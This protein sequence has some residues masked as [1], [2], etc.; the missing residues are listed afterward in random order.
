MTRGHSSP[1]VHETDQLA[2]DLGRSLRGGMGHTLR[3]RISRS[4][5]VVA[6]DAQLQPGEAG[7]ER[8]A[9]EADGAV[10]GGQEGPG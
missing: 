5:G 3:R 10:E 7:Q 1:S 4:R 8:P 6:E 2:A 9:G